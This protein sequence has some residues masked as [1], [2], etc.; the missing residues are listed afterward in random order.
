MEGAN[1]GSEGGKV[2]M[3]EALRDRGC[4]GFSWFG[5]SVTRTSRKKFED[6]NKSARFLASATSTLKSSSHFYASALQTPGN[7][8]WE[9]I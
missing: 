1:S 9:V 4:T 2:K 3:N 5:V 8:H 6:E 7:V